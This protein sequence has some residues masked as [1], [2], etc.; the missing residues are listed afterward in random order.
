MPYEKLDD[1]DIA[2]AISMARQL[3]AI[4]PDMRGQ[5]VSSRPTSIAEDLGRMEIG[6]AH[7]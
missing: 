3:N 2:S 1:E 5:S 7:V 6:R 4:P